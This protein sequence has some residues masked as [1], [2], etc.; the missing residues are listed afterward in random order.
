MKKFLGF[1]MCLIMLCIGTIQAQESKESKHPKIEQSC[2][3]VGKVLQVETIQSNQVPDVGQMVTD[4]YIIGY[5]DNQ[6][7]EKDILQKNALC[8]QYRYIPDC[9]I[10]FIGRHKT[11]YITH[12]VYSFCNPCN[13]PP[14]RFI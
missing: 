5:A 1:M 8:S 7:I 9:P 14:N 10:E 3:D 11:K 4:S 13:Q 12:Y 2:I 6:S